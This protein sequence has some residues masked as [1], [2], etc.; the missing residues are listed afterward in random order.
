[1]INY[2]IALRRAHPNKRILMQKI[3]YKSAYRRAHLNWMT[4]IQSMTQYNNLLY[5]ALRATFGGCP[6]PYEWGV[7]S[8]SITDLAN[9]LINDESW[10]PTTLDSHLQ[11]TIPTDKYM[12]DSIPF[13]TALPTIVSPGRLLC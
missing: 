5:I 4:S 2:I 7:I 8:E 9:L 1:M 11:Q 13:A 3:D 6:N 12:D 10:D